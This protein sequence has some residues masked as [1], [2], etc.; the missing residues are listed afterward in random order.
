MP[1]GL[2]PGSST[3]FD[4]DA[5]VY[6]RRVED[7]DG[8]PLEQGVRDAV[9]N[10]VIGCKQDGI[11][12]AIRFACIFMG[13]R[14]LSGALTP[15]VGSAP[16]NGNFVSGDYTRGG[17][18]PGLTGNNSTKFLDTNRANNADPQNDCHAFAYVTRGPAVTGGVR[19]LFGTGFNSGNDRYMLALGFTSN[20][21]S[22]NNSAQTNANPSDVR[23][24]GGWGVARDGATSWYAR[25][26]GSIQSRTETSVT[27]TATTT[28]FFGT[29]SGSF[30]CDYRVSF[31]S[32]G[33]SLNLDTLSS[34]VERMQAAISGALS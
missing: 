6:L 31:V 33:T 10:F 3:P 9:T 28:K 14:T 11:W 1:Y 13:A 2:P 26:G 25:S 30:N 27:P 34:R 23:I 17:A 8:Q 4:A 21:A 5:A 24:G 32:L 22:C 18:L 20:Y 16:T 19:F 12:S 7:A 29:A 15:L